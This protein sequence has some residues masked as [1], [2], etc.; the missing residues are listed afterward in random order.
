MTVSMSRTKY[1]DLVAL[2]LLADPSSG[3][4]LRAAIDTENGIR[5][6]ALQLRWKDIG[7]KPPRN[8]ELGKGWPQEMTR[9]LELDRPITRRDVDDVLRQVAVN[10]AATMVTPDPLGIVGWTYIDDYN[11]EIA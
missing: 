3:R 9:L 7:G 2:A 1:E 5:R 10:P 4:S 11:F 8:V 6:Y